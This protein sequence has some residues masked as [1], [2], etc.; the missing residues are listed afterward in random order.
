MKNTLSQIKSSA[1]V[2]LV[3][4]LLDLVSMSLVIIFLVL[5]IYPLEFGCKDDD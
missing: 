2:P 4:E 5:N 3:R 1:F